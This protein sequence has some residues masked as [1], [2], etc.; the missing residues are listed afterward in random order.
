[1][2]AITTIFSSSIR[3]SRAKSR[4]E[5]TAAFGSAT[6]GVESGS[7]RGGRGAFATLSRRAAKA[8]MKSSSRTSL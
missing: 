2:S 8:R 7:T 1:M 4:A 3:F 6:Q 5:V